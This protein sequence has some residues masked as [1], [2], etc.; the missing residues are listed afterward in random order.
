MSRRTALSPQT[1]AVLRLL[2]EVPDRW[3]H[4]YDVARRTSLKSGTLYPILMRLHERGLLEAEWEEGPPS[5][6]PRRHR[7]RLTG[8]GM[9][10]AE[11]AME[12]KREG[13]AARPADSG[14][15]AA[16]LG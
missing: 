9:T 7:Y 15:A 2:M 11:S 6:R 8:K 4:G 12:V 16:A 3:W 14:A 5:G 13:Q 1:I 10:I